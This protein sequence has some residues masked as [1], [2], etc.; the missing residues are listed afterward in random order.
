MSVCFKHARVEK[1]SLNFVCS[2]TREPL[3]CRSQEAAQYQA[4]LCP[5]KMSPSFCLFVLIGVVCSNTL[6]PNISVLTHYLSFREKSTC[7]GS[8][9]PRLVEH[10]W[11]P[12]LG[13]SFTLPQKE[14]GKRSLANKWRQKWQKC[15]KKWPES[16]WNGPCKPIPPKY[17][18]CHLTP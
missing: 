14:S 1:T 16:G 17:W 18:G 8:R 3:A 7:K 9:T 5:R 11:V 6:F 12:I 2:E 13:A 15:Q 10:F 4:R